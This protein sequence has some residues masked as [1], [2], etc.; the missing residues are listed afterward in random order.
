M[1]I[2][3]SPCS[4]NPATYPA[5]APAAPSLTLSQDF[6]QAE[7]ISVN[8]DILQLLLE[9]AADT[10]ATH[11]KRGEEEFRPRRLQ[12]QAYHLQHQ[13]VPWYRES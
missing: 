11:C 4:I 12:L 3:S 6:P 7:G 8:D 10:Q 9:L 2:S 5:P 13:G 1:N